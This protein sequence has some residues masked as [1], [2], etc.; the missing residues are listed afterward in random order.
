MYLYMYVCLCM[1]VLYR[2]ILHIA[3]LNV[4]FRLNVNTDYLLLYKQSIVYFIIRRMSF[5]NAFSWMK[6]Y[7]FRL[8]FHWSLFRRLQLT[9]S[10]IGSDNGLVPVKL[11]AITSLRHICVTRPQWVNCM[12]VMFYM[13]RLILLHLYDPLLRFNIPNIRVWTD[14]TMPI[15]H[16][17]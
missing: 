17:Y 12:S 8:R 15:N 11:Q 13:F 5:S 2:R 14:L 4:Q 16:Y 3:I 9:V 10:S 1:R 7:A 6:M